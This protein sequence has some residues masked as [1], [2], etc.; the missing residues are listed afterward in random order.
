MN[1]LRVQCEVAFFQRNRPLSWLVLAS[2]PITGLSHEGQ[3]LSSSQ[4][5]HSQHSVNIVLFVPDGDNGIILLVYTGLI[6][7]LFPYLFGSVCASDF[8]ETLTQIDM[9]SVTPTIAEEQGV[10]TSAPR[11]LFII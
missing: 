11:I 10:E 5:A 2:C 9:C 6:F 3:F 4:M 1:F 7:I 8:S